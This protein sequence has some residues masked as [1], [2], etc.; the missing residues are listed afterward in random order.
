MSD[1]VT[2]LDQIAADSNDLDRLSK[3]IY[4][5]NARLD[6]AEA[7]WDAAYD[8]VMRDLEDEFGAAGRKS[9]PEHTAISA[10]RREHR[11]QYIEWREAKRAVERLSSQLAAKRAALSGRQSELNALRD[12][13][14]AA[15]QA[16]Q[17]Q[18]VQTFGRRAA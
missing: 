7:A 6:N 11:K 2:V 16:A 17:Q 3:A 4:E 14:R 12:E 5:A 15:D 8:K 10:A 18:P 13:A 9:V 1:P